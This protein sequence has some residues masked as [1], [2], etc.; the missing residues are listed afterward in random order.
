MHLD[1]NEVTEK[2][3]SIIQDVLMDVELDEISVGSHIVA[4]LGGDSLD[5]V[6][7]S[8][9]IER[10]FNVPFNLEELA[11]HFGIGAGEL[12]VEA[13]SKMTLHQLEQTKGVAYA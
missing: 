11:N 10:A 13:L 4:D 2:V 3:R 5:L 8:S 7:I 12:T 9:R 1:M 6:D